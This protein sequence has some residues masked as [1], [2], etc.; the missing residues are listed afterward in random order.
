MS[1]FRHTAAVPGVNEV[2]DS[3]GQKLHRMALK[4][5]FVE[6][7]QL[8]LALIIFAKIALSC[9]VSS[10]KDFLRM[11]RVAY[12][13]QCYSRMDFVCHYRKVVLEALN[14]HTDGEII[15]SLP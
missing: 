5:V 2:K 9:K 4:A 13:F 1:T 10:D 12:L 7:T 3:I 14:L 6:L 15:I 8:R 11:L